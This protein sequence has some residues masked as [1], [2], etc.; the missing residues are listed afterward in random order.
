[1]FG[2]Y[3]GFLLFH[4]LSPLIPASLSIPVKAGI[5]P[6]SNCLFDIAPPKQLD[7]REIPAFAGMGSWLNLQPA[8]ALSLSA[9]G[10]G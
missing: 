3:K 8:L 5:S 4:S 10:V 1:M 6:I 9:S 7:D 2:D